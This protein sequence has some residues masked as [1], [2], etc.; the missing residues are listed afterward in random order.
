ML[1]SGKQSKRTLTTFKTLTRSNRWLIFFKTAI[2]NSPASLQLEFLMQGFPCEYC[3]IF[4]DSFFIEHL[5]W[6][7]H[8]LSQYAEFR[9]AKQTRLDNIQNIDQR[10]PLAYIL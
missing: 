2:E 1:N 8:L 5:Q 4:K 9:E 7:H 3:K 6:H 10:Q